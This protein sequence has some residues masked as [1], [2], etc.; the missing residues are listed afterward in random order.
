MRLQFSLRSLF[1]QALLV[2]AFMGL[3]SFVMSSRSD[4]IYAIPPTMAIMGGLYLGHSAR[5]Q[6][7]RAAAAVLK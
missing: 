5:R 2:A 4:L 1:F 6:K 7:E 3:R